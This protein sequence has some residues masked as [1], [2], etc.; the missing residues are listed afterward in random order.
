MLWISSAA[1]A[2]PDAEHLHCRMCNVSGYFQTAHG[3]NVPTHLLHNTFK[4]THLNNNKQTSSFPNLHHPLTKSR[5]YTPH[6]CMNT[7]TSSSDKSLPVSTMT[8]VPFPA[9]ERG[10]LPDS[11]IH[12]FS[13]FIILLLFNP[14]AGKREKSI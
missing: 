2:E 9:D 6:T 3:D 1:P 8:S 13:L 4:H 10:T 5:Y 14:S 11:H 12:H 7:R